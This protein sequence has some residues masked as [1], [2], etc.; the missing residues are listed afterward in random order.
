MIM[1]REI[2]KDLKRWKQ[3]LNLTGDE[4]KLVKR[5]LK[6]MRMAEFKELVDLVTIKSNGEKKDLW[7]NLHT[8]TPVT[9]SIYYLNIRSLKFI[10]NEIW[11][12]SYSNRSRT[13]A[14][15]AAIPMQQIKFAKKYDFVHS[16]KQGKKCPNTNVYERRKRNALF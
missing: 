12:T 15:I 14:L 13:T 7:F 4:V 9:L 3:E 8:F 16:E 1:D 10:L 5:H 2:S 11:N 6:G